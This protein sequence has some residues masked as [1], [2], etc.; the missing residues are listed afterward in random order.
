MVKKISLVFALVLHL[1]DGYGDGGATR[2]GAVEKF[3]PQVFFCGLE[4]KAKSRDFNDTNHF[5]SRYHFF[6]ES[7]CF[8]P[9][10]PPSSMCRRVS[11]GWRSNIL[12]PEKRITVLIFFLISGW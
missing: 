1:L 8:L 4:G 7:P 3:V 11:K 9:P 6:F 12:G 2:T 5:V 10:C